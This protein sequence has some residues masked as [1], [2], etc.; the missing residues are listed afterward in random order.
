MKNKG[1]KRIMK[2]I[3]IKDEDYDKIIELEQQLSVFY[4]GLGYSEK[5]MKKVYDEIFVLYDKFINGQEVN[6]NKAEKTLTQFK[7]IRQLFIESNFYPTLIHAS[8][9][10]LNCIVLRDNPEEIESIAKL[11]E[12]ARD[13]LLFYNSIV[14]FI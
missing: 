3:E 12:L 9:Q 14:N 4:E 13:A 5:E 7:T 1:E 10:L 6:V 2:R 8:I 11:Q